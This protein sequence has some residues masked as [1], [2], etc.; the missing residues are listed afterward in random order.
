VTAGLRRPPIAVL[1]V[2]LGLTGGLGLRH[3]LVGVPDRAWVA[4]P[5]VTVRDALMSTTGPVA[6]LDVGLITCEPAVE[7]AA[8]RATGRGIA[9]P[10]RLVSLTVPLPCAG[11]P[12]ARYRVAR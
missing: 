6:D 9:M 12:S 4:T 8:A 7:I 2:G 10:D 11:D 1:A 3:I 5:T